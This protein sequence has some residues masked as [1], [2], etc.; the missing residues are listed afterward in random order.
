MFMVFLVNPDEYRAPSLNEAI[1]AS[2]HI[3]SSQ[4]SLIT[5]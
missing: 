4:L 1:N 2:F 3:L 5:L